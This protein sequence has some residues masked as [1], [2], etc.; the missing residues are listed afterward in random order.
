MGTTPWSGQYFVLDD[1]DSPA[2]YV[3]WNDAQSFVTAVNKYTD[4]TFRLPSEA[5]WEYACRAGNQV[6]PTR[7][8]WGDDPGCTAIGNYAWHWGNC[9]AEEYAHVV[10]A[11]T[12]N[13]FG[14]YDMS[15]NAWEWV[16]DWYHSDYTGAPENGS[17]WE[18]PPGLGRVLRGGNWSY[19]G[20]DCRS[21][22]RFSDNPTDAD[23]NIGFR[24]AR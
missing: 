5:Q 14:L 1:P 7:F 8:Y 2:V 18:S 24:L 4:L 17:A 20:L 15:G 12:P 21:A 3:S 22:S 13:V 6:P 23:F 19:S 9:S 16:Q 11:R 10:G